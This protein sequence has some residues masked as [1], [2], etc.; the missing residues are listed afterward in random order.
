MAAVEVLGGKKT[1]GGEKWGA[2]WVGR[3][4]TEYGKG[5]G[6]GKIGQAAIQGRNGFPTEYG[7]RQ[8]RSDATADAHPSIK[9]IVSVCQCVG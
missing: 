4:E 7:N 1:L 8:F 5:T 9:N 6:K 2:S 3:R